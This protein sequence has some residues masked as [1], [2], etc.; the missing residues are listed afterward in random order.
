MDRRK[1]W[2]RVGLWALVVAWMGL[3]FC[4]SLEPD[5]QSDQTSGG[6]IRCLLTI[7]DGGFSGLSPSEQMLR[8]EG[9]SFAVR[10][11]AHLLL[12]GFCSSGPSRWT[13][14]LGGRS[15][16]RCCWAWSGAF[17]TR[18]S[19]P[20]SRAGPASFETCASTPSACFWARR[21]CGSCCISYNEKSLSG[22]GRLKL[23]FLS[24]V[25][26]LKPGHSS[27]SAICTALVAAPL[28]T[29][30]PQHQRFNPLSEVRS[31]RIRPT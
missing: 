12:F 7:L 18:Y 8:M 14:R 3:I 21:A 20:S 24:A 5:Y 27:N 13:C 4:F 1:A 16:G 31:S 30:S 2:R 19:R 6:V 17:W 28:R 10:K 15:L 26:R 23:F 9:W 29:W 11:L 22:D 25:F